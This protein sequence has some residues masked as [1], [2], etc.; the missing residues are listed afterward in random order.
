LL[1]PPRRPLC[2]S[3]RDDLPDVPGPVRRKAGSAA[4]TAPGAS[5]AFRTRRRL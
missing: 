3:R 2:P 4:A 1:F 5:R